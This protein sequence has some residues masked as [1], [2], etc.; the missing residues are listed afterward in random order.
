ME[1]A[2]VDLVLEQF[3]P[4]SYSKVEPLQMSGSVAVHPHEAIVLSFAHLH[5]TVQVASLEEGV[6]DEVILC[7]PVLTAEG[8]VGE[9]HVVGCLDVVIGERE[10]FVVPGVVG[11]FVSGT[12]IDHAGFGFGLA[13][14]SPDQLVEAFALED[15]GDW[16][17]K[18]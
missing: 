16:Y 1:V 15:D 17:W 2:D 14:G 12:Q 10:G 18:I 13:E 9:L 6:E 3:L 7:L 8:P 4:P 11:V 5:H